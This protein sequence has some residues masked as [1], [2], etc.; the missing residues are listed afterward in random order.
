M[1][2]VA[3]EIPEVVNVFC[4]HIAVIMPQKLENMFEPITFVVLLQ[5][6]F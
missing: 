1:L 4:L 3:F 2:L 6:N 5:P